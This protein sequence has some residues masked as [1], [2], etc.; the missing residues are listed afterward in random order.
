[1]PAYVVVDIAVDDPQR[2]EAYKAQAPASIAA[3]GGRY[4]ARGGRTEVLEGEWQ[5]QRLVILEFPT[6]ERAKQW[7][8]SQHYAPARALR[9]ATAHTN[10]VLTEGL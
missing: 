10:M 7:I 9:H 2:Y 5:P 1:M 8:D 6:M 4:L 3:H